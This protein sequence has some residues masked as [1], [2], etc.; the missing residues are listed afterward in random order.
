MEH[1]ADPFCP[2]DNG[3]RRR[4]LLVAAGALGAASGGWAAKKPT[5]STEPLVIHHIGPLSGNGGGAGP[6]REFIS[7]AQLAFYRV[8]ESGG[9]DGRPVEMELLDDEQDAAKTGKLF[10]EVA[11]GGQMLA[12][13]MPRT[14]PSIRVAMAI[15]E[16]TGVPLIAPQTGGS[17]ITDPPRR[18]VFAVRASY[19]SEIAGAVQHFHTTGLRRF[20]MLNEEGPFGDDVKAGFEQTIAQLKLGKPAVHTIANTA[21]DVSPAMFAASM[22]ATPDVVFLCI[23]AEAAAHYI[24]AARRKGKPERFVSLSNTSTGNVNASGAI[25]AS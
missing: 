22:L 4:R 18:T 19:R 20:A 5:P 3:L 10:R 15:S 13:F 24:R 11:A 23:S 17:F 8:N 7:G 1:L 21:I 16:E 2:A 25:N 9:I 12:L 6:N 14:S